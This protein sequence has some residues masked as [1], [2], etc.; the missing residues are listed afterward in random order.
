MICFLLTFSGG[1][2]GYIPDVKRWLLKI[3]S[4]RTHFRWVVAIIDSSHLSQFFKHRATVHPLANPSQSISFTIT[5]ESFNTLLNAAGWDWTPTDGGITIDKTTM[6]DK[7]YKQLAKELRRLANKRPVE[8]TGTLSPVLMSSQSSDDS[9]VSVRGPSTEA[10][11]LDEFDIETLYGAHCECIILQHLKDAMDRPTQFVG[12]SKL[13][14]RLC[15][16][17]FAATAAHMGAGYHT[18]GSHGQLAR[19]RCPASSSTEVRRRLGVKLLAI[20]KEKL[21]SSAI[22]HAR[23]LSQSTI[24][25]DDSD[26]SG[27]SG[28]VFRSRQYFF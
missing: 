23:S 7:I 26:T 12:V 10:S 17:Y 19:W 5:R 8:I 22:K 20:V 3:V 14:C 6:A 13:S 2:V 27:L 16:E 11:V 24:P 9:I 25:S 21:E 15:Q 1:R 18:R 4:T 28:K